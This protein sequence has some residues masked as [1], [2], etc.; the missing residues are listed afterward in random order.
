M[1]QPAVIAAQPQAGGVA[2]VQQ[3]PRSK[4][5]VSAIR[6]LGKHASSFNSP[7]LNLIKLWTSFLDNC[8]VFGFG[9]Y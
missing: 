8:R 6:G 3:Q 9:T 4:L 2:V 7:M 1:Q 5:N